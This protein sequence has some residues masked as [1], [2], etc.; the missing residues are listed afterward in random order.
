MSFPRPTAL[1]RCFLHKTDRESIRLQEDSYR[2]CPESM[3]GWEFVRLLRTRPTCHRL[4]RTKP[5][6]RF[7]RSGKIPDCPT[8]APFRIPQF[9]AASRVWS[10]ET[11]RADTYS[12]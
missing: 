6:Q 10:N 9:P 12:S 1:Y 5:D 7:Q 4:N 3:L 11:K 2:Y 8:S